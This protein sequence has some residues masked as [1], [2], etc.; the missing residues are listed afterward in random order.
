MAGTL[1]ISTLSDGTNSTS[2]TNPIKGSAKAWVSYDSSGTVQGSFNVSSV[3]HVSTGIYQANFTTPMTTTTY[4][5]AGLGGGGYPIYDYTSFPRNVN[6]FTVST[7]YGGSRYDAN[8]DIVIF[9]P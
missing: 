9:A 2:A 7:Y 1:T 8:G 6:Y 3:T 4:A 5:A